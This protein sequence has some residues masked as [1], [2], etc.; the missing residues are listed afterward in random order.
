MKKFVGTFVLVFGLLLSCFGQ[1][2]WKIVEQTDD[3]ITIY[4]NENRKNNIYEYRAVCSVNAAPSAV[5]KSA[6]TDGTYAELK[7]YVKE[8][9][10]YKTSDDNLWYIYQRFSFMFIN[11]RDYTLQYTAYPN[12]TKQTYSVIWNIANDKMQVQPKNVIHLSTCY[13]NIKIWPGKQKYK[14]YLQYQICIDPGGIIP[15][16]VVNYM[17][18]STLPEVVRAIASHAK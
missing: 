7:R 18:K 8:Q 1:E 2:R 9:K 15:S 14:S 10:L 17:N 5:Y 4:R 3:S 11:D 6:N 16:W 13:G 12:N